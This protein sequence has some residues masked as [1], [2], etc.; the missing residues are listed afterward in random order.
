M[1]PSNPVMLETEALNTTEATGHR[2]LDAEPPPKKCNNYFQVEITCQ[3][4]LELQQD[5]FTFMFIFV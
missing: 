3:Y 4:N 1:V 2:A 5:S